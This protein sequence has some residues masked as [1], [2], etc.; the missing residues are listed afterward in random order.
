MRLPVFVVDGSELLV[1]PLL[2]AENLHDVHPRNVL[3]HEGVEVGYRVAHVV[4]GHLNFFL[5]YVGTQNQERQRGQTHQRQLP[6]DIEHH[7]QN[8]DNL[9][10]V[11]N[12][13]RDA[14]AEN[15]RQR[16]NVRNIPRDE[17]TDGGAVEEFEAQAE[18]VL[19]EL[20]TNVADHVL[21]QYAR[22]IGM[23]VLRNAL[24][25]QQSDQNNRHG[26]QAGV[27]AL[28]DVVVDGDLHQHRQGG[29]QE[30]HDHRQENQPVELLDVGLDKAENTFEDIEVD[31]FPAARF[32]FI[33]KKQD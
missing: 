24:H 22:N 26:D 2:A 19:V 14:L 30:R 27:V 4:E 6:I 8:D 15:I 11:A 10:Q 32:F 16:L 1:L 28:Q 29:S 33:H 3:L 17:P 25:H 18:Q 13:S 21:T 5:K 31:N 20:G 23:K 7:A 9:Q 12:D